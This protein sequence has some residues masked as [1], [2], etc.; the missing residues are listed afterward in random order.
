[1][2]LSLFGI[3]AQLTED[4]GYCTIRD[5]IP[6]GP[7][8]KSKQLKPLDRI[9]A[10]AQS[11]QPPVDVVN[12]ELDKVVQM[13]RGPKGTE[14]RLTISSA[15]DHAVRPPVILTRD[16]IKLEDSEA[17][18]KL[19]ESRDSHGGT[20]RIGVI[21]LPSFYATVDAAGN[22]GHTHK[23]TTEDVARLI[24]KLK[25]EKISGLI[26]DL[27]NN[28]GGSLEEAVK[29][30][31][32]FIKDGPVVLARNTDG[33]VAVDS[34]T[35]SSVAYDGPLVVLVNRFS[36]SASEIAAAALQDYGRALIIGDT[37]TFGKGTVQSLNELKPFVLMGSKNATND[38]GQLK[39][40]IRNFYRINGAT[41]QL[42]G[43]EPDI[44]LPDQLSYRT[45][46]ESERTLDN[47][48]N[49][50]RLSRSITTS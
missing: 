29:F 7:A 30:T 24:K 44:V 50:I 17:K 45:D 35:D 27:R 38:P 1:M 12:M 34:D 39:I 33:Q 42:K 9:V 11:N 2:S 41:T 26:V 25:Q 15:G 13:I 16:E 20:N 18:A 23:S 8:A 6:G 48:S 47:S 19:L 22:A 31:G 28:P 46:I 40:T 5:L 37:S 3:G 43:V 10:V 14:V 36:A 49:A 32:L 21:D 4:D